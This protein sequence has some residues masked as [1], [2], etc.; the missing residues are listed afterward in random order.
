MPCFCG[1]WKLTVIVSRKKM[2]DLC[3]LAVKKYFYFV[4]RVQYCTFNCAK[5][6][7]IPKIPKGI[8][9][10]AKKGIVTTSTT[11]LDI[12]TFLVIV[13]ESTFS[14]PP[15]G[16]YLLPLATLNRY[17]YLARHTCRSKNFI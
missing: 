10:K 17:M 13:V 14:L 7:Q 11:Y 9:K 5:H 16:R 15:L 8:M 6:L 2:N 12:V 4:H 1:G 3:Q